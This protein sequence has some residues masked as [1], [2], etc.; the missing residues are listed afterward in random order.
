MAHRIGAETVARAV[1]GGGG[2]AARAATVY[3]PGRDVGELEPS[4]P[5]PT[6][7]VRKPS[8]PAPLDARSFAKQIDLALAGRDCRQDSETVPST[9]A[10]GTS[11]SGKSMP[12]RSSPARNVSIVACAGAGVPG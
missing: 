3:V 9:R 4:R 8:K 7:V 6:R 11:A 2:S 1:P 5:A 10:V 12:A